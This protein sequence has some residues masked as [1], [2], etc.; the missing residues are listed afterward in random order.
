MA[1]SNCG[2]T[3]SVNQSASAAFL[4]PVIALAVM[5]TVS[6]ALGAADSTGVSLA[7][8]PQAARMTTNAAAL[9]VTPMFLL[10]FTR[11][12]RCGMGADHGVKIHYPSPVSYTHLRAHETDSYLVCRLLLEKKKKYIY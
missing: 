1:A 6:G 3:Q 10:R 9:I 11:I 4:P 2:L 8:C 12:L 5:L 7:P